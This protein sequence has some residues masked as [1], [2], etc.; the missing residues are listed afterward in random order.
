MRSVCLSLGLLCACSPPLD[1]RRVRPAG[2]DMEALFPCRPATLSRELV[3]AQRRVEMTMHACA[4]GGSTY[5]VGALTLD[6]V[7]DVGPALASLRAAA[8][9]NVGAASDVA[10][11]LDVPGTTPHAQA[12][13]LALSGRRPDGSAVVEHLA[14]F[15]RG[16]RVYQA[17][18]VGDRPDS[19]AVAVFFS[20]LKVGS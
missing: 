11:A 7:R 4:A 19:E 9:R 14:V 16:T 1:W 6:D 10:Q 15:T 18:V 2:L 12:A 8:M 5:A 13:R 3:L 17:T 20:G